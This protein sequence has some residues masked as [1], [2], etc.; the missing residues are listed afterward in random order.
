MFHGGGASGCCEDEM[1]AERAAYQEHLRRQK[2]E[3]AAQNKAVHSDASV[4]MQAEHRKMQQQERE[5]QAE[6]VEAERRENAESTLLVGSSY[7][8]PPELSSQ[9]LDRVGSVL[10]GN[11]GSN[12]RNSGGQLGQGYGDARFTRTFRY[13]G[14]QQVVVAHPTSP[15]THAPT[16]LHPRTHAPTH[17]RTRAPTHPRTHVPTRAGVERDCRSQRVRAFVCGAGWTSPAGV[18]ASGTPT[19]ADRGGARAPREAAAGR[20]GLRAAGRQVRCARAPPLPREPPLHTARLRKTARARP[21]PHLH[22]LAGM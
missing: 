7:G 22:S 9:I 12:R 10:T 6:R 5:R 4:A 21:S 17:P 11:V 19:G 15:R 8:L 2:K 16:H 1:E 18:T 20:G 3:K 14:T 13:A